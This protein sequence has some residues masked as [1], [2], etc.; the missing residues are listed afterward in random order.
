MMLKKSP[1]LLHSVFIRYNVLSTFMERCASGSFWKFLENWII[2]Q[3]A[4]KMFDM[5]RR[6]VMTHFIKK[7]VSF[8]LVV[9]QDWFRKTDSNV[10]ITKGAVRN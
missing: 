5:K 7:H 6:L 2:L 9:L 4:L 3:S 10:R 1:V 8:L